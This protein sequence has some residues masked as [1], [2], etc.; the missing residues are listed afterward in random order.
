MNTL[1]VVVAA[2]DSVL[3]ARTLDSVSRQRRRFDDVAVVNGSAD[4]RV[5]AWL[6]ATATARRWHLVAV[7]RPF[8]GEAFNVGVHRIAA[9]FVMLLEA[10]DVLPLTA[11]ERLDEAIADAAPGSGF[12][13]GAI[14]LTGLGL[15]QRIDHD[16][17][18]AAAMDPAH[19]ALRSI[20]WRRSVVDE[21]GGLDPALPAAVRYELWL[22]A[23]QHAIEGHRVAEVLL[24]T[25]VEDGSPLVREMTDAA[26]EGTIAAV[27]ARYAG[28]LAGSLVEVLE[29]RARRV[30]AIG[31]LHQ[32]ALDRQRDAEQRMHALRAYDVAPASATWRAS[33][34][35]RDWGYERGGPLD[36][37]YIEQF[38][39][40]HAPDLRGAVLE[41]QEDEYTRRYGGTAVTRSDVV[42]LSSRNTTATIVSDLRYAPNIPDASYDCVV[43][44]QTVHVIPAMAEVIAE[45][46]RIL[47]PGGVLLLTAPS[48]SRVCLEYGRDGDFWRLT[49]AGARWLVESTFG[50]AVAITSFGNAAAGSAFLQGSGRTEVPTR[51]LDVTDIYNPTLV[52]VRAVK[53]GGHRASAAVAGRR[54]RSGVVLLYHRVGAPD[55]D[56]HRINADRDAFEQQMAWLAGSAA[57][58]PL[59]E[60]VD[61]ARRGRLPQRAVAV[62]FDD[63]Y[64]D[65]LTAAAGVIAGYG[66]PAT[67]F[68]TTAGLDGPL[69]FWWDQ[70]AAILLGRCD[71]RS[72]TVA[73]PGGARA[74]PVSTPGERLFTHGVIYDALVAEPPHVRETV[75]AE[76]RAWAADAGLNPGCRR[77]TAAEIR[78]LASRGMAIGAHTATHPRL[79][80][81]AMADQVEE[82]AT[83]RRELERITG[84]TVDLLAYP[85]GAVDDT[86]VAAASEAGMAYAFTCEPGPVD[87]GS[88][89]LRLPRVDVQTPPLD[90]FI[91]ALDLLLSGR[92]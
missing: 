43:L 46:H 55:P 67:C 2:G 4:A 30:G 24:S 61:G 37:F 1:G 25:S 63:G 50:D 16:A 45:V 57:V 28:L 92:R 62:T 76:L 11:A 78:E 91:G 64:L 54:S 18:S 44:T 22:R 86:T 20:A 56:P 39:A 23:A 10:G 47:R 27:H 53:A 75:L 15:D 68:V 81:L 41:V 60:L 74:L 3:T 40:A 72:L 79:P 84:S 80:T 34:L 29:T 36:R 59:P 88:H 85:F 87:A 77:M 7:D 8:L 19:P 42:D 17:P 33:P 14:R 5:Q 26:Y 12:V 89:H 90:R 65:T 31:T 48:V 71:H 83:S 70:L 21:I 49:P 6:Q 32:L 66:L 9:D 13:A 51:L 58:L 35:S 82:I 73:L 52:G 38:L 69:E